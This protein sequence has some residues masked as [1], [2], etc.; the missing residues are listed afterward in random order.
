[1]DTWGKLLKAQS[2]IM[3]PLAA[4]HQLLTHPSQPK[5]KGE[6]NK[7]IKEEIGKNKIK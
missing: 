2:P 1:M 3:I 5:R 7:G 6:T 4:S